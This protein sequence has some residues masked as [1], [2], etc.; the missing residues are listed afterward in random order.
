M[1]QA[2]TQATRERITIERETRPVTVYFNDGV[3]AST[4]DALL[5]REQGHDPVY[6]IPRDRVE[7]SFLLDSDKRTTC[8]YKGEARHWTISAMN[9]AAPDGAWSYENP[10]E[11]VR[12][13]AGYIAFYK[14]AVRI[15]VDVPP[16]ENTAAGDRSP[17]RR[18]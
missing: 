13:I 3:I 12:E 8:P 6:Y 18:G 11:G 1:S 14:D 5:L 16:T 10:H 4:N 17:E 2:P 9:R 15:E 7:M